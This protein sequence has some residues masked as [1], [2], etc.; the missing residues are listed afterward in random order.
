M[1]YAMVNLGV[2]MAYDMQRYLYNIELIS[3]SFLK[4]MSKFLPPGSGS[5][6]MTYVPLPSA[7]AIA[8]VF[9]HNSPALL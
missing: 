4:E 9:C 1:K 2:E 6:P 8:Q 5:T 7:P 3:P